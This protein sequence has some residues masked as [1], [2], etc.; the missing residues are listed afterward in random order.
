MEDEWVFIGDYLGTI[1]EFVPGKGTF[2]ED[3]KI[4]ASGI[5]KAH[6]DRENHL[7]EV[8]AK[9]PPELSVNMIVYGEVVNIHKNI[10]TVIVKRIQGFKRKFDI[11]TGI[12]VSNISESYVENPEDAFG[13]G[14]IVVGKVIKI[15]PWFIDLTTRREFGVVKAFCKRCRKE[16]VVE[17]RRR[18]RMVCKSCGH[19]ETRKIAENYG[20]VNLV[21]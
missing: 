13:I 4:F 19:K 7:V 2:V 21:K 1:E 15:E 6:F 14:D 10:V 5:G 3:G 20:N 17:D 9:Q 8:K 16:L 11:K 12:F 18:N